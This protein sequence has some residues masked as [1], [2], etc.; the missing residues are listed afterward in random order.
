M[1]KKKEQDM[2]KEE[3]S[4]VTAPAVYYSVAKNENNQKSKK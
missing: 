2:R 1:R 4:R 3:K